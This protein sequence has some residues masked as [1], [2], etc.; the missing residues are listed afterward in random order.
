MAAPR[1]AAGARCAASATSLLKLPVRLRGIELGHGPPTCSSISSICASSACRCAAAIVRSD[2]CRWRPRRSTSEE[3]AASSSLALLDES[4]YYSEHGS[5]L[6][7]APRSGRG[8][9]RIPDRNARRH[10][11]ARQRR[12]DESR[13]QGRGEEN[14]G[15]CPPRRCG[16]ESGKAS[17]E[18][19]VSAA[20]ASAAGCLHGLARRAGSASA[21]QLGSAAQVQRRRRKRL[22]RQSRRLCDCAQ[23]LRARVPPGRDR[24]VPRRRRRTTTSG[25]AS[26]HSAISA[27][28]SAL[29]ACASWSSRDWPTE[30][31]S[32]SFRASSRW[33]LVRSSAQAMA[34]VLVTPVNFIGNK[35]WSFRA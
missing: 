8:R 7:A 11:P 34:I 17:P 15:D 18:A 29:R 27:G 25:I 3:I 24:L 35:L 26:G 22:R 31:I 10:R 5:S 1:G 33:A 14:C 20:R 2:S 21:A 32:G 12:R 23:V 4:A 16:Y 30:R 6:R 28:T 19:I 13:R 9:G